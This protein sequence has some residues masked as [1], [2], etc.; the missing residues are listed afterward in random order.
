MPSQFSLSAGRG[1]GGGGTEAVGGARSKEQGQ[2]ARRSS[3]R[4]SEWVSARTRHPPL[5]PLLLPFVT[6]IFIYYWLRAASPA[7]KGCRSHC[8]F[9]PQTNRHSDRRMLL[10]IIASKHAPTA[11]YPP[12]SPQ[13]LKRANA[14]C[15]CHWLP[16]MTC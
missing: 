6:S 13:Q 10:V 11:T 9:G 1:E 3:R 15:S 8:V 7:S 5:L 2:S 14:S 16:G 4:N 12:P